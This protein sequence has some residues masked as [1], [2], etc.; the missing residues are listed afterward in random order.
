MTTANLGSLLMLLLVGPVSVAAQEPA[1]EIRVLEYQGRPVRVA[2]AGLEQ[3]REGQPVVVFESGGATPLETWDHVLPLVATFAPVVAYD[4]PGTG[5]SGWDEMPPTPERVAVRLRNLLAQMDV[6]PPYVLVGHSW[7]GALA[8]YFVGLYPQEV[9]GALFLDPTDITQSPEDE[10]AIF[11]SIGAGTAEYDA[12][13]A[14]MEAG[15]SAVPA[16]LQ[17]EAAVVLNL[18]RSEM[19]DRAIPAAPNIPMSVILAGSVAAPPAGLLPFDTQAYARAV[20]ESRLIRLAT[21]ANPSRGGTFSVAEN[22]GHFIHSEDPELVAE[23]IR[24]LVQR[25]R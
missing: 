23:T 25:S 2:T 15:M 20:F 22:S 24:A 19:G 8:R 6:R 18:M 14:I 1:P 11:E 13:Y 5:Q 12:F 7:G 16:P 21:W 3:R 4:R 9:A 17:A 10:I